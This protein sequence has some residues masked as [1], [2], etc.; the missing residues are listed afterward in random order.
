MKSNLC[1]GSFSSPRQHQNSV[2]L[3]ASSN[4]EQVDHEARQRHDDAEVG[5]PLDHE[6]EDDGADHEEAGQQDEGDAQELDSLVQFQATAAFL[7]THPGCYKK[8]TCRWHLGH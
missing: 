5:L 3:D 2:L 7:H 4:Q 6:G 8:Q 1:K